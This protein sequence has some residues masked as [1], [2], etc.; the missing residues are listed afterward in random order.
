[1]EGEVN[2][3][4]AKYV[5]HACFDP[6]WREGY[7]TRHEAYSWLAEQMGL[8]RSECHI[9]LFDLGMCEA[10]IWLCRHKLRHLRADARRLEF[11]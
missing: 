3:G 7:M 8:K 2:L 9:R 5:A 10:V 4:Q 6:I 1:M 11:A